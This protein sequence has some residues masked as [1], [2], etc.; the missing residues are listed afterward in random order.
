MS[1]DQ[2]TDLFGAVIGAADV[3][4]ATLAGLTAEISGASVVLFTDGRDRAQRNTRTEALARIGQLAP[5][6]TVFTIGLGNEINPDDLSRIGRDGFARSTSSDEL[7][8]A[9]QR[10]GA[11]VVDEAESYYNFEYCSPIRSGTADLYIEARDRGRAGS[12]MV[13][14]SGDG[15]VGGCTL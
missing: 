13:S 10:V 9:F 4:D 7:V 8:A 2:T 14:Y 6:V 1:T 3:T 11:G 5:V 12:L 15:F